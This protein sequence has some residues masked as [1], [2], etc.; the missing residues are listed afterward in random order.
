MHYSNSEESSMKHAVLLVTCVL[1]MVVLLNSIS[2]AS[3]EAQR[4]PRVAVRNNNP[5][6]VYGA[7]LDYPL[8]ALNESFEG[9]T[10]PPT[11]WLKRNPDLGTGWNRQLNGTTPVPGWQGGTITVPP[12]GGSAVA[13]CSWNTGGSAS[14][15]QWLI[16]PQIQNVGASDSLRFYMRWWPNNYADTVQIRISTGGNQTSDFAILVLNKGFGAN[17]T[18]DTG[19]V[20]Y[21]FKLSDFVTP[22]SNIYIAFREKVLDNFNDGASVSLDLVQV[23]ATTGVAEQL[24]GIPTAFQLEQNYP[25]PFNPST[26]IR[27]SLPTAAEVSLKVFN[28]L[29]Q[30]VATVAEGQHAPGTYTA[31][32]DASGMPSGLY[33]YKLQAGSYSD[34]KRLVLLK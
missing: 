2:T 33:F 17:S 27:F 5:E 14:N 9:T 32:W 3:D 11:G 28:M 24:S 16:T 18:V 30:E 1:G 4:T 12:G 8:T 31:R 21:Q 10:F 15:D 6:A 22:G 26:T 13:F 29:G 25:N 34:V 20:Q 23:T 7:P 19:W